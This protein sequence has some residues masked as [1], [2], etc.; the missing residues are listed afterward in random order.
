MISDYPRELRVALRRRAMDLLA[1]RE[2]TRHELS[3]KLLAAVSKPGKKPGEKSEIKSEQ[4]TTVS[5]PP[6]ES[7]DDATAGQYS[8]QSASHDGEQLTPQ[9]MAQLISDVLD[10]L[11]H[12]KLLSDSRFTESYVNAR[13]NRGYGPLYIR[14]QLRQKQVDSSLLDNNLGQ[15]QQHQ[16]IEQVTAL[17]SRRI[18]TT[19]MPERG[20]KH[21][22]KLQ[23]F[24]LS[25]GFTASQ[26]HEAVKHFKSP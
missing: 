7:V 1:R 14:H 6:T 21:Y 19:G 11:E 13:A 23:R 2:H 26:W 22:L 10:K 5:V 3:Q 24:I 12:D 15:L 18:S 25:R 4:Q 20:S 8:V 16:W 9:L 17:I